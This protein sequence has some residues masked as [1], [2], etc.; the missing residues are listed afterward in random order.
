MNGRHSSTSAGI[1]KA[2]C[3]GKMNSTYLQTNS[4]SINHFEIQKINLN[5][6]KSIGTKQ[7]KKVKINWSANKGRSK[8]TIGLW[9]TP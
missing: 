1:S 8:K 3:A 2:S 5:A 4:N 6:S 9:E 7:N